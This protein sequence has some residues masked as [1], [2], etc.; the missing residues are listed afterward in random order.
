VGSLGATIQAAT[1]RLCRFFRNMGYVASNKRIVLEL[2]IENDVEEWGQGILNCTIPVSA[3]EL[4][5]DTIPV[6]RRGMRPRHIEL[7]YPS[8][9][10]K[11]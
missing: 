1:F 4:E 10:F 8:I 3:S 5:A 6:S 7:Y 11:C 2:G 9:C